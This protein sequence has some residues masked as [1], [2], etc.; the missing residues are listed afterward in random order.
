MQLNP[1]TMLGQYEIRSLIGAGGMGEVYLGYDTKLKRDVAL[2]VLP[3]QF[4]RDS[5]RLARFRRE[6]TVLASLNHRNIAT[7][8]GLEESGPRPALVMEY[9]PG[10]TLADRVRRDGP[11]PL[12]EALGMAKQIA[13]ALEHAHEK[14]IVHRDLKPANVKVTPEGEIKVLDFGLAKAF[15]DESAS[16][17]T[18]DSP[19]LSAMP[20]QP[21]VILGT[22]A[23]MSPEQARGKKVDRRTDIWAWGCVLYELLTGHGAFY[24]HPSRARKQA[25]A[26]PGAMNAP[27]TPLP[28]G[29]GSDAQNA[30]PDWSL[31]PAD[32]P[33]N[34]RFVLRRCLTKDPKQRFRDAADVR[35]QIEEAESAPAPVREIRNALWRRVIT[36]GLL[37]LIALVVG[38]ASS[39][40][41]RKPAPNLPI[42]LAIALPPADRM[43]EAGVNTAP[44]ALSPDGTQ[45]VYVAVHGSARQLYVR[46]LNDPGV[47]P[48]AGTEGGSNP[49]FSPNGQWIGFTADSKLKKIALS[50]GGSTILANAPALRGASWGSDD[51]IVYTP[52]PTS[53]LWR[54]SASGGPAQQLTTLNRSQG[55]TTHRYP[56]ILPGS[57]G[58]LFSG[59]N[60]IMLYVAKTGEIRSLIQGEYPLGYLSTGHIIYLLQG[61][62]LAVPFDIDH[63][64]LTSKSPTVILEGVVCAQTTEGSSSLLGQGLLAYAPASPQQNESRLVWV[65]RKGAVE[66]LTAPPR[67][68]ED[69]ALSPDGRQVAIL[70]SGNVWTVSLLRGTLT[71]I[72]SGTENPGGFPIWSP[73][74]K[75]VTYNS[76]RQG[77]RT[78]SGKQADGTGSEEDL[79]ASEKRIGPGSWSPDGKVLAYSEM[80]PTAGD[81]IWMLPV[82]RDRKA[83]LWLE[84]PFTE[85]GAQFSPDGRWIAYSSDESGQL[86]VYVRPYTGS[87]GK[88]QVSTDGGQHPIWAR[89]GQ[90]LFYRNGDKMMAVAVKTSANFDAGT[91][92]LLFEK[93]NPVAGPTPGY[94]I[95]PDGQRF[96]MIQP[97]ESEQAATQINL[98]LN[99]F[100][101]LKR[102]VP[103]TSD[104]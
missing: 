103:V 25:V 68:F 5:D 54:V 44:F 104:K 27:K 8:Y 83:R 36:T 61:N 42:H 12:D 31:L 14:T 82:E 45:L 102:R 7:I 53:S 17:V 6:A 23:Y 48:I 84:T 92:H 21:G 72:N 2:K 89:N 47:K 26:S 95:S 13:E 97:I 30:E 35:I 11:V 55:E 43:M 93:R 1:G 101:E 16:V 20:T 74:G 37:V 46:S 9:V 63:L 78:L 41:L 66:Q 70:I 59:N 67:N 39:I 77:L 64:E 79:I 86:E 28:A 94:A 60:Q 96:L 69:V 51:T 4:S 100:E 40:W 32:T 29:R 24:H 10:E 57:R 73:D 99:W 19:T 15:A 33:A 71:R 76:V 65:D 90:E 22:A 49:F 81:D 56:Q 18:G 58:V 52:T 85:V 91:P 88:V 50:G 80:S 3:E 38:I 87:G 62:V 34:I 98:V 75:R